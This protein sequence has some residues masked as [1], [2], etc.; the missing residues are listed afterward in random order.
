M[1]SATSHAHV[2]TSWHEVPI[3]TPS[4][5]ILQNPDCPVEQG[6]SS[7]SPAQAAPFCFLP[8]GMRCSRHPAWVASC[9]TVPCE[10]PGLLL[11]RSRAGCHSCG[12]PSPCLGT[13]LWGV[14]ILS[15]YWRV[16]VTTY[17]GSSFPEKATAT[18]TPALLFPLIFWVP[19]EGAVSRG[20]VFQNSAL[21]ENDPKSQGA[22]VL[23]LTKRGTRWHVFGE[24]E[25]GGGRDLSVC[26]LQH[27]GSCPQTEPL[28]P[29]LLSPAVGSRSR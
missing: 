17:S 21:E 7:S 26:H 27:R 22:T 3:S 14:C 5:C 25:A 12:L 8:L 15:T 20:G 10:P 23:F 9:R 18:S 29:S 24:R 2:R 4:C 28:A 11:K 13:L 1:G 6:A 16:T 19:G